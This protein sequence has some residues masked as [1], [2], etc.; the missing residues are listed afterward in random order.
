MAFSLKDTVTLG[1]WVFLLAAF[2]YTLFGPK[3][4]DITTN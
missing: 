3:I 1:L 2:A 4:T